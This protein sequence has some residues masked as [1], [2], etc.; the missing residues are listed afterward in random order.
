MILVT[1]NANIAV[2][3][4]AEM[5]FPM[6]RSA[7]G[8][9]L[10][11]DFGSVVRPETKAAAQVAIDCATQILGVLIHNQICTFRNWL[12]PEPRIAVQD[13][14]CPRWD[15]RLRRATGFACETHRSTD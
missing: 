2:L 1:H 12:E 3:G 13:V 8:G 4:D 15:T 5:I 9:E 7:N 14:R 6:Q 11:V 10:A